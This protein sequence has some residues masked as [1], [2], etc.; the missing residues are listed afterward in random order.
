MEKQLNEWGEILGK[1][2]MP[3][4]FTICYSFVFRRKLIDSII[5]NNQWILNECFSLLDLV[6]FF[7]VKNSF[8]KHWIEGLFSLD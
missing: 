1:E 5:A 3:Y 6:S 2:W 8:A 4:A 7:W